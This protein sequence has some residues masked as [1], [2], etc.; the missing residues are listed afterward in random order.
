MKYVNATQ[1]II[2]ITVMVVVIIKILI[3]IIKVMIITII[4][5]SIISH[6]MKIKTGAVKQV[7]R[8]ICNHDI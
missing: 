1:Y 6:R 7:S 3:T 4:R 5:K 8:E 2:M